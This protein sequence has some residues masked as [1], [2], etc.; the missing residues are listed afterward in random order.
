[1]PML[2]IKCP[3]TQKPIPTGMAV[4]DKKSFENSDFSNNSTSCPAC[5]GMH[6]WDKKDV[7]PFE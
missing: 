4:G 2:M 3:K 1:M 7:L 5:G 6:K